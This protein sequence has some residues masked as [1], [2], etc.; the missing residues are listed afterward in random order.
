MVFALAAIACTAV[1]CVPITIFLILRHL[2]RTQVIGGTSAVLARE[3]FEMH[4]EERRE[5]RQ[6]KIRSVPRVED[7]VHG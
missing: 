5:M 6:A 3:Q 4:A 7:V 2:E 1:V